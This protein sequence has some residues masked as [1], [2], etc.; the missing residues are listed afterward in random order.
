MRRQ[1]SI[2]IN[3]METHIVLNNLKINYLRSRMLRIK[4]PSAEIC[5]IKIKVYHKLNLSYHHHFQP[6]IINL[7]IKHI[8][9]NKLH[10]DQN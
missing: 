4:I 6:K 10:W 3:K 9:S 2:Y 1:A 7:K 5:R 8:N